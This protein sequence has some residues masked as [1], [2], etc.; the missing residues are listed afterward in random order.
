MDFNGRL[1]MARGSTANVNSSQQRRTQQDE[2]DQYMLLADREIAGCIS[3]IGINF[4]VQDLQKPNP[5]QIQKVFEWFAELLMNTTR[6]VVAPAM[7]AAAEDMCGGDA[8]RIFTSDTRDL[9]GFFVV[10]RRLAGECGIPDLTFADLYKPTHE[11]LRKIFSYIINF[12]RF[13]ES[14]TSVIDLHFNKSERTKLRIES[15]YASNNAASNQLS[16]LERHKRAN[17]AALQSKEKKSAELKARLLELRNRQEQVGDRMERCKKESAELKRILENK[18]TMSM[19]LKQEVLKLKPY[20]EQSPQTLENSL[21]ELNATLNAEKARVEQLDRRARALQTSADTFTILATDVQACTRLLGD[22]STELGKWDEE[23]QKA[24][25][26]RDALSDRSNNVRD[27]ERQERLLRKQLGNVNAR[28]EKLRKQAEERAEEARGKM[29]ELRQVHKTLVAD[30]GERGREVER[31][32]VRIEQ[33][34]KKMADLKE[35]IEQEVHA[36]HDEYLKM[37][38]HIKLYITEMEQCIEDPG[39]KIR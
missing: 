17:E 15:L 36:A 27:V 8:D 5:Q 35:N 11:R 26:H 18:T 3:D 10:L 19:G 28:T 22:V 1:S 25:R 21:R 12:I 13:R 34:E 6:E 4:T 7:R 31:R 20:T 14:Q 32:R 39:A 24:A 33:T 37:E 29:E 30:R 23:Q 38:S 16:E 2:G 9:M